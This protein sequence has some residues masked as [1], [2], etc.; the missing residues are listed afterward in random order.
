MLVAFLEGFCLL[1]IAVS[2]TLGV[3]SLRACRGNFGRF[4][5]GDIMRLLTA[6]SAIADNEPFWAWA[7]ILTGSFML[8]EFVS[9]FGRVAWMTGVGW[10][11]AGDN[12]AVTWL[13]FHTAVAH[14]TAFF[15]WGV[16]RIHSLYPKAHYD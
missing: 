12:W 4:D 11:N 14:S 2:L 5:I 3:R 1:S 10:S 16:C 13:L 9:F 8:L 6:K 7:Y 15:H